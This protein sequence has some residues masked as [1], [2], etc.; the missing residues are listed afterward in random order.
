MPWLGLVL[1]IPAIAC[2]ASLAVNA[3]FTSPGPWLEAVVVP[4]I[5]FGGL[6]TLVTA[7]LQVFYAVRVWRRV[8]ITVRLALAALTLA[9]LTV[10]F[11]VGRYLVGWSTATWL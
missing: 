10:M 2:L 4:G 11:L 6:S 7:P 3:Q 1:S 5:V 9:G 8:S